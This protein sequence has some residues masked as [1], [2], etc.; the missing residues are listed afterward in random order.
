[1]R[2]LLLVTATILLCGAGETQSE[3]D[4]RTHA[5]NVVVASTNLDPIPWTSPQECNQQS[6]VWYVKK[7]NEIKQ[8]KGDIILNPTK[9]GEEVNHSLIMYSSSDEPGFFRTIRI[10]CLDK[11]QIVLIQKVTGK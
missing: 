8:T 3:V 1:M 4:Q 11:L 6:A 5:P 2:S 7:I 9:I 10:T